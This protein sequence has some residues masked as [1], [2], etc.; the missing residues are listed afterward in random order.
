MSSAGKAAEVKRIFNGLW[1]NEDYVKTKQ[2][3][4]ESAATNAPMLS[5]LATAIDIRGCGSLGTRSVRKQIQALLHFA[6]G[7]Q[8]MRV[9]A[10]SLVPSTSALVLAVLVGSGKSLYHTVFSEVMQ[11]VRETTKVLDK[12]IHDSTKHKEEKSSNVSESID[13]ARMFSGFSD[14]SKK[15]NS[16]KPRQ[17]VRNP[18]TKEG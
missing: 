6:I 5:K 15:Q 10:N 8:K 3:A 16:F 4:D 18:G 11:L 13:L 14:K 17:M 12:Q 2:I 1:S 9:N 7:N